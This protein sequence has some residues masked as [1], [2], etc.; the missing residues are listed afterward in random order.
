MSKAYILKQ[1]Q[2]QKQC[3]TRNN[4]E[5]ETIQNQKQYRTRNDCR[6]EIITIPETKNSFLIISFFVSCQPHLQYFIKK[7]F[8]TNSDFLFRL[9]L[10]LNVRCKPSSCKDMGISNLKMQQR[11][12]IPVIRQYFQLYVKTMIEEKVRLVFEVKNTFVLFFFV[13]FTSIMEDIT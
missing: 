5:P 7:E 3:R 1:L 10:Q 8:A 9:S 4:S 6:P 11:L 2:C 12:N 13:L